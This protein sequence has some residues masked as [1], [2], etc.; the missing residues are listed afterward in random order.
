[1]GIPMFVQITSYFNH[2]NKI[3]YVMHDVI[4]KKNLNIIFCENGA[5]S[6]KNKIIKKDA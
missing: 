1:M 5:R 4:I 2:F 3:N 6:S